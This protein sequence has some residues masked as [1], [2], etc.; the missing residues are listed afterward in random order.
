[1]RQLYLDTEEREAWLKAA[2]YVVHTMWECDYD[3]ELTE[4][5]DMSEYI[6][7]LDLQHPINPRDAFSGGRC[8]AAKLYFEAVAEMV[9]DYYDFTR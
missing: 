6:N 5:D 4:N 1:M 7:S 3:K 2:G 9:I 8:N